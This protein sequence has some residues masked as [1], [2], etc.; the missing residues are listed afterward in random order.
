MKRTIIRVTL[1]L[2][3]FVLGVAL[4]YF[5]LPSRIVV[6]WETVSEV[7]TAGFALYR[8]ESP[9]G[10]FLPIT[11]TPISAKGDPLVGASYQ[12]ED[13]GLVWGRR[14]FYRLEEVERSGSRNPSS[15]V[16]EGR[17]GAG[18]PWALAAGGLLAAL[19]VVVAWY[20]T[21]PDRERSACNSE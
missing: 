14:Y 11:E 19:G 13:R 17:A 16:I 8:G 21:R 6:T 15:E 12:Y 4:V 7:D 18:W 20:I 10:P 9:D 2:A 5:G 3:Y 1:P